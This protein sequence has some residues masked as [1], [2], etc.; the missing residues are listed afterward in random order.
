MNQTGGVK[1]TNIGKTDKQRLYDMLQSQGVIIRVLAWGSLK[2]FV[3]EFTLADPDD[4]EYMDLQVKRS[5]NTGNK[6]NV[7]VTK[8]VLKIIITHDNRSHDIHQVYTDAISNKQ[9]SKESEV[10]QDVGFEVYTQTSAFQNSCTRGR[11]PVCPSPASMLFFDNESGKRFTTFLQ[12]KVCGTQNQIN[13]SISDDRNRMFQ[14]CGYIMRRLDDE[15]GRGICLVL[16]PKVGIQGMP[17]QLAVAVPTAVADPITF[18][19]F[20]D[21]SEG[22]IFMGLPVTTKSRDDVRALLIASVMKLFLAGISHLDLHGGNIMISVTERDELKINILDLGNSCIFWTLIPNRFL[23]NPSQ[24]E[25]ADLLLGTKETGVRATGEESLRD[26]ILGVDQRDFGE[27]RHIV[28]ELLD[29]LQEID[30]TGNERVFPNY[31]DHDPTRNQMRWWDRI[32]ELSLDP[33]NKRRYEYI[34]GRAFDIVQAEEEKSAHVSGRST[35]TMEMLVELYESGEINGFDNFQENGDFDIRPYEVDWTYTASP[36]DIMN[37]DAAANAGPN[38]GPGGG[39]RKKTSKKQKFR[40][41]KTKKIA[42]R[43]SKRRRMKK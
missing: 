17:E 24:K 43:K 13:L 12:Q 7:P 38:I 10:P 11:V 23:D 40:K 1:K 5:G 16:M 6:F 8:Y 29:K 4:S 2:C 42:L 14:V 31:H 35:L 36:A 3:I 9:Y 37:A 25:L 26:K 41:N 33:L 32:R 30:R 21:L 15:A 18:S 22:D 19:Q 20:M 27:K 34:I 39:A 28:S